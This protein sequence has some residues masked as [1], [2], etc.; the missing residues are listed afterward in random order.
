MGDRLTRSEVLRAPR[1]FD[2]LRGC[3]GSFGCLSNPAADGSVDGG[4]GERLR[5]LRIRGSRYPGLAQPLRLAQPLGRLDFFWQLDFQRRPDAPCSSPSAW[6]PWGVDY[7]LTVKGKGVIYGAESHK[8]WIRV[9]AR[10]EGPSCAGWPPTQSRI[11]GESWSRY[12]N[13]ASDQDGV[14]HGGRA[15]SP[16]RS[17]RPRGEGGGKGLGV[18]DFRAG[19]RAHTEEA[20][21]VPGDRQGAVIFHTLYTV[22][23]GR[24]AHEADS[25]E[26]DQPRSR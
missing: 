22:C 19:A 17:G 7:G 1:S 4:A 2:G 3:C 23:S 20:R 13:A 15:P 5:P 24:D 12:G 21:W 25:T 14:R 26:H 6:S 11:H 18:G 9:R 8:G 16:E 10:P